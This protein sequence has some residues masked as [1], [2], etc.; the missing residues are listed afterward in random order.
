M[1][2]KLVKRCVIVAL[3]FCL[4]FSC[5]SLTACAP[6]P[7]KVLVGFWLY[8]N[9]D[10]TWYEFHE[11]GTCRYDGTAVELTTTTWKYDYTYVAPSPYNG[12]AYYYRL[13]NSDDSI[14]YD[15]DTKKIDQRYIKTKYKTYEEWSKATGK[16]TE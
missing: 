9:S 1:K 15:L 8:E 5:L 2:S 3:S 10:D 7:E 13:G 12:K 4:V 14:E 16:T 11:D 6:N